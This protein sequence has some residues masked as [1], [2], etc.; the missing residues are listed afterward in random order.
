MKATQLYTYE[1]IYQIWRILIS[2]SEK[3]IIETRDVN[4]KEVFFNCLELLNGKMIFKDLQLKEK[5]WIGIETIYKDLIFL[6]KF[7]KPDL[8]GH[9]EII[10]FEI[11]SKSVLWEN[12]NFS[13]LFIYE[14]H[15][16]CYRQSFES[17]SFFILDYK[18]GNLI[19]SLGENYKEINRLKELAEK[20][21]SSLNYI[22]PEIYN[23]INNEDNI[24]K[25]IDSQTST[26]E[27]KGEIEYAIY[28]NMLFFSFHSKGE[29]GIT[30]NNFC[31]YDL[32]SESV[33]FSDILNENV[34]ALMTDSFFI[35][36]NIL[37]L[38][39]E[40]NGLAVYKLD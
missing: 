12:N 37:F 8:P 2:D 39:K 14:D 23:S 29:G 7:P 20:T 35:Y 4:T 38:L 10:V 36:K 26:I 13:F 25:A 15:V 19:S 6:H 9:K 16:Y 27:I 24:Y 5:Y 11:S 40:K 1:S 33:L 3:L 18:N 30:V 22:F 32:S 31:A 17:R 34:S 21:N 28:R